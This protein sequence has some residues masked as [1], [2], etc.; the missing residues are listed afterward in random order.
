MWQDRGY[1][2]KEGRPAKLR[3]QPS[4]RLLVAFLS[5]Y[6]QQY[7]DYGFTSDLESLLDEVSGMYLLNGCKFFC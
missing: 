6:F 3:A 7:I 2:T 1:V 4:G 5:L